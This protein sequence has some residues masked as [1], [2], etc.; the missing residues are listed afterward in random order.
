[1]I[2]VVFV[3]EVRDENGNHPASTNRKPSH[4]PRDHSPSRAE[5]GGAIAIKG[6]ASDG[7]LRP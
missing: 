2:D 1:M 7:A 4:M 3:T 5:R 6:A